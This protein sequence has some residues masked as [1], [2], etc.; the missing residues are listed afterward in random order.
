[1]TDLIRQRSCRACRKKKKKEALL[2]L[3]ILNN[4][5][6]EVDPRQTLPG[7]GW[8]LCRAE[9]CLSCLKTLKGRQKA[10]GRGLEIGPILNN[11]LTIPLSGG[12]HGQN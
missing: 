9:N 10:F 11:Y 4:K 8:Y 2:R 12:E 7:R 3:V 1:M 6:I 5:T